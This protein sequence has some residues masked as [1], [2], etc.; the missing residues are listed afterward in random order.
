MMFIG[1]GTEVKV[2]DSEHRV[3]FEVC[4][5]ETFPDPE[6]RRQCIGKIIDL[7]D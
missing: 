6:A 3:V 7:L 1:C 2:R 4:D 5:K